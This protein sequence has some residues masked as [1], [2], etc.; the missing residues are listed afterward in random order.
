MNEQEELDKVLDSI[1]ID[2]L[3][4]IEHGQEIHITKEYALYR[5]SEDDV[6]MVNEISTWTELYQVLWSEDEEITFES[7][8]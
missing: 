8:T 3:K 5:Y 2:Q 6:Y 1:T 7:L 4:R